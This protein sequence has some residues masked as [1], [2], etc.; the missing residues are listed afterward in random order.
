MSLT[1]VSLALVEG[2]FDGLPENP[3]FVKDVDLRYVAANSAMARLCGVPDKA[4]LVGQRADAFFPPRLAARYEAFDR[5]V[6]ATGRPI[7]NNLDLSSG[8]GMRAIWLI[9]ARFPVIG[10]DGS[11]IGVAASARQ[12]ARP[13]RHHPTYQRLADIARQIRQ[14]F[15][16]PLDLGSLARR[17]EISPSQLERDFR[18]VFALTPQQFHQRARIDRALELLEGD[19]S[20]AQVA[21]ACGY[22]DHSAFTRRFRDLVGISPRDWRRRI[23]PAT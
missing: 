7:T 23:R 5:Q 10:S 17:A 18:R 14:R 11:A 20:I 9:F 22:A 2:L 8:T 16:L 4:A 12:L 3:F 21:H 15:D 6:I 19:G 13:D 1:A